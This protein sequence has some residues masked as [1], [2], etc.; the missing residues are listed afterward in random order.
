[1]DVQAQHVTRSLRRML[2]ALPKNHGSG[3]ELQD[4]TGNP[5]AGCPVD[6]VPAIIAWDKTRRRFIAQ[7]K[8]LVDGELAHAQ[9]ESRE[10]IRKLV[11]DT[12]ANL[13]NYGPGMRARAAQPVAAAPAQVG[14]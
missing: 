4:T 1:M 3:E 2:L 10:L 7:T 14:S 13:W 9:P 5:W 12:L 8:R 11:R 6:R